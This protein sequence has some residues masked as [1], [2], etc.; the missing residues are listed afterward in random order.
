MIATVRRALE[1][2]GEAG[3]DDLRAETG[4]SRDQIDDALRFL[5]AR[6]SVRSLR[7]TPVTRGSVGSLAD[8][9]DGGA[10]SA[11]A[12]SHC[13]GCPLQGG[14]T[15]ATVRSARTVWVPVT[16]TAAPRGCTTTAHAG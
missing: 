11:P 6:G 8:L 2:L 1:R 9:S 10:C 15:L 3:L 12:Q 13:A 14:C 7:A 5:V 4:L 16:G